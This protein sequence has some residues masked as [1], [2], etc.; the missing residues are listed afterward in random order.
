MLVPTGMPATHNPVL[1]LTVNARMAG[2]TPPQAMI[3]AS[4]PMPIESVSPGQLPPPA[5]AP[6][7]QQYAPQPYQVQPP[8]GP[9]GYPPP[10][11]QA[12]RRRWLSAASTRKDIRFP[13]QAGF[14][15]IFR[16]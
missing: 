3:Q 13:R 12:A 16:G 6:F 5:G 10:A 14:T 7:P 1:D 2:E 4:Q 8:A 9:Q 11:E 15:R